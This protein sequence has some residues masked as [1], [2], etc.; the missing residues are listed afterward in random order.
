MSEKGDQPIQPDPP[1]PPLEVTPPI[2]EPPEV[3]T[4]PMA[5]P[6]P[7]KVPEFTLVVWTVAPGGIASHVVAGFT[8]VAGAEAAAQQIQDASPYNTEH[9]VLEVN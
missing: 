3:V 5:E 6:G 4:P 9:V 2:A 8:T 1:K 7:R